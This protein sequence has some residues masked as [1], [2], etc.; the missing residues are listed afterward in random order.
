M[1]HSGAVRQFESGNT[2]LP[3]VAGHFVLTIVR[4]GY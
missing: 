1:D 3:G 2:I 4:S